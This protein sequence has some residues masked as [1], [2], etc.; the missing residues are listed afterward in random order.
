MLDFNVFRSQFCEIFQKNQLERFC[1][2]ETITK[3]YQ[4]TELLTEENS[5]TN[6]TAIREIPDI[7]AKHYAD[8]LLAE[9]HFPKSATVMDVGCGG[10][11]P[12]IPLAITRPD[13]KITAVDS[14]QKK[15]NFVNKAIQALALS[16]ASAICARVESPEMSKYREKFDIVTSRAMARMVIL[17]ELT[18]PFVKIGGA[19]IA[20]KGAQ[21]SEE[22]QESTRAIHLL[23]GAKATEDTML[24]L[25][26]P[27]DSESRH[28]LIARK[29]RAT[30][31]QYPRNYATIAK[32]PL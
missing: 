4:F 29:E 9:S 30:P 23:G 25:K 16:N 14:T 7:I 22:L 28:I 3:F 17:A 13:L 26:T 10:G 8:S 21:G 18:L 24:A 15:I 5:H 1:T 12:S 20:L 19:L 6:L 11:F 32:K 2:D 27:T 31:S